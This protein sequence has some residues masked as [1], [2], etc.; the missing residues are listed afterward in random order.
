MFE[1]IIYFG[2]IFMGFSAIMNPFSG[3]SIFL[4]LTT[5]ENEQNIKK[6]A[7]TSTLTAFSIVVIFALAGHL[8]LELFGVSFTALRLSGGILVGLIGYEMLQGRESLINNPSQQ[9]IE[10][11]IKEE[12]SVALTPLGTPLLAGPGVIITA[13]NFSTGGIINFFITI[14]AFGLL[15]FITYK[16]FIWGKK[17]KKI[18][19]LSTLKAITRMMGLILVVIGMQMFIEGT[20]S[21]LQEFPR[22]NYF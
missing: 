11:T 8:L 19:G 13:M 9:T 6:I 14:L 4:S 10:K 7:M 15:C 1:K 21:A 5:N 16:F 22:I 17:I 18:I 12:S 2:V 3:V 20:Y